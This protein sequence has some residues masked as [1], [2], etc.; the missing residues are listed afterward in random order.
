MHHS[1]DELK[2]VNPESMERM[3]RKF[4]RTLNNLGATGQFPNG[5]WQD[6]DEG[7][8]RFAVGHKGEKVFI[9]FGK[10]VRWIGLNGN[11]AIDLG[12]ALLKHGRESNS[13]K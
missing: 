7:E 9:E 5:K 6:S 11:Q 10:S 3:K 12:N 8:I 13:G 2:N 1:E 4:E